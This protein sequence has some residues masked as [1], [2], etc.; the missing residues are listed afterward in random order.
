M[1]QICGFVEDSNWPHKDWFR[2]EEQR[3]TI[4]LHFRVSY[5]AGYRRRLQPSKTI[6]TAATAF[7][8]Y[9]DFFKNENDQSLLRAVDVYGRYD[10]QAA[11]SL[12]QDFLLFQ[13]LNSAADAKRRN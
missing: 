11:A 2:G 7:S 10:R 13:R 6:S 5:T 9:D 1:V 4:R 12:T 8:L 3:D